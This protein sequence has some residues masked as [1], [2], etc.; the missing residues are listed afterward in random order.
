M[1]IPDECME[2]LAARF[3]GVESETRSI[4]GLIEKYDGYFRG[5]GP[6]DPGIFQRL[7]S[8]EATQEIVRGAVAKVLWGVAGILGTAV[9]G[10]AWELMNGR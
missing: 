8:I 10:F 6:G 3:A 9:A 5:A 2:A 4:H 7:D 1:P